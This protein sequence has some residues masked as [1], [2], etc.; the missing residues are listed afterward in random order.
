MKTQD[1]RPRISDP[2]SQTH[3]PVLAAGARVLHQLFCHL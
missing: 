3:L 1:L 2:G